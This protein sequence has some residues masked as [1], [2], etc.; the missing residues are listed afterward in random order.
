MGGVAAGFDLSVCLVVDRSVVDSALGDRDE[1]HIPYV[2][3]V[4]TTESAPEDGY[5]GHFKVGVEDLLGE[6]YPKLGK[7]LTPQSLWALMENTDDV[8]NGDE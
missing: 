3:A 4:D 5:P 7:G 8:W 2:I 1:D 6:F